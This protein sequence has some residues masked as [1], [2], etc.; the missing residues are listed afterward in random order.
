MGL[1]VVQ[2]C[3]WS[4]RFVGGGSGL[5]CYFGFFLIRGGAGRGEENA[6]VNRVLNEWQTNTNQKVHHWRLSR[7]VGN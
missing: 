2:P 1:R 4:W 6:C 7:A 5:L 3:I